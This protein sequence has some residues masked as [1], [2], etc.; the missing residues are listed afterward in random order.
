MSTLDTLIY[1]PER[2]TCTDAEKDACLE[3]VKKLARLWLAVRRE[4]YL[5]VITLA[6]TEKDPFFRT[7]LME[8]GDVSEPEDLERL[9]CAYL[10]AG[11]YRGGAFLNAVLIVKGLL[12]LSRLLKEDSNIT[13]QVWGWRL[14][15]ELRGFFGPAYRNRVIVTIDREAKTKR[16]T[17]LVP[18]FDRLSQLSL[19]QRQAL[20]RETD[21]MTLVTA[22]YGASVVAEET[23]LGALTMEETEKMEAAY[24]LYGGCPGEGD[25]ISAQEK[26]IQRWE[27]M[28]Q[29]FT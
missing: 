20:L 11:N 6:E 4:G 27:A 9:F 16:E 7:C 14:S 10:A 19:A 28:K 5:V 13:S 2:L 17:S 21:M 29:S 12:L 1:D 18:K 22:L 3:T 8:S 15:E 23:L 25:V 24:A 26:M